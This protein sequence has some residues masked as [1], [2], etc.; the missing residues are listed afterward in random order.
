MKSPTDYFFEVPNC[1]SPITI[2][3]GTKTKVAIEKAA[4]LT[5]YYSDEKSV[6][7]QVAFGKESSN[8]T[9]AVLRPSKEE[10]EELRIT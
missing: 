9:V 2:L 10:V 1:G 7:V 3:Q 4:A 5:A 6:Q 8:R